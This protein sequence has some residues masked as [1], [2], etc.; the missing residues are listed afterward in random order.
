[1][2]KKVTKSGRRVTKPDTDI[3]MR[4]RLRR[5]ELDISQEELGKRLGVSFQQVQKYEKGINRVSAGRL[6]QIASALDVPVTFFYSDNRE[7][8]E[9]DSLLFLD[10]SFSLRLLRAYSQIKDQR[11]QRHF[12]TLMESFAAAEAA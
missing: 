5:V 3:G 11:V 12:V 2:A 1:M 9:V 8:Q 7:V 10:S 4:V 6:Q